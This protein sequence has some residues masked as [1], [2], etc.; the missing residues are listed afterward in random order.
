V[1]LL[2]DRAAQGQILLFRAAPQVAFAL[3]WVMLAGGLAGLKTDRL[4]LHL[5]RGTMAA[6]SWWLYYMSFRS[7]DLALATTL[8]FSS[9]I[10]VVALAGPV[11]GERI[12]APRVIATLIGFAG[13]AVAVQ[14]WRF[15]ALNPAVLYGITSALFGAAM[16]LITRALSKTERT[17][18]IMFFMGGIVLLSAIPQAATGWQPLSLAHTAL[19]CGVGLF[20][21]M[22]TWLMVEAYRRADASALAPFPYLRLIFAAI[23]GVVFFGEPVLPATV[24][25]AL[26]IITSTLYLVLAERR[27]ARG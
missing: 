8:S 2:G 9:Q 19:L 7:L 26:L 16:V 6:V 20:G 1:R 15:A 17:E 13:I 27:I 21:T 24:A 12:T 10:F 25:G 5:V 11:L 14:V 22:G 23:V 18:V 4:G 3:L